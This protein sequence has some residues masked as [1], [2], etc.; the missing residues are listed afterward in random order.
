ML[1]FRGAPN[2]RNSSSFTNIRILVLQRMSQRI[3]KRLDHNGQRYRRH[4]TDGETSDEGITVST[5][6]NNYQHKSSIPRN[7]VD[8]HG[9]ET[10]YSAF[11]LLWPYSTI[12]YQVQVDHY[13]M[14][15]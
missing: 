12:V 3:N 6:L 5:I 4:G 2:L 7:W 11:E 13:T 10:G 9:E 1:F 14:N 8:T 15:K